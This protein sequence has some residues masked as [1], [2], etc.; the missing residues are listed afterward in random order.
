MSP[1]LAGGYFTI[2]TLGSLLDQHREALAE[3]EVSEAGHGELK[4]C[5]KK[6]HSKCIVLVIISVL[7]SYYFSSTCT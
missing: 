6:N 7:L 1:A 5:L 4:K 3:S 2:E